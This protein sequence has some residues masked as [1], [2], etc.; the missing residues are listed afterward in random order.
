[1]RHKQVQRFADG[2][3]FYRLYILTLMANYHTSIVHVLLA[4]NLKPAVT[5]LISHYT[6]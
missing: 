3:T 6:L 4:V 5:H 2:E 1:M